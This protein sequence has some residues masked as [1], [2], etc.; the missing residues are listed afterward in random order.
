VGRIDRLRLSLS[1]HVMTMLS[2]PHQ[3]P[4][5]P[6][7]GVAVGISALVVG[8]TLALW[9]HEGATIFAEMLLAGLANCF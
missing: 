9:H 5:T 4:R 8:A 7:V 6:A 1:H 2:V 3:A